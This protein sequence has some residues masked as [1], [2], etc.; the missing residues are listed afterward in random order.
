MDAATSTV[1][2]TLSL[3]VLRRGVSDHFE[4]VSCLQYMLLF[5]GG[6]YSPFQRALT[7]S[8]GVDGVFGPK[9]EERVRWFQGNEGL[10]VDGVVGTDTWTTLLDRWTRFQTAG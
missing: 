5:T 1:H 3:P 4:E 2:V 6:L 10:A 8:D 7:V 9:T